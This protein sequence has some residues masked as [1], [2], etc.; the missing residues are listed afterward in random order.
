MAGGPGSR[1]VGCVF[2][3]SLLQ[4]PKSSAAVYRFGTFGSQGGLRLGSKLGRLQPQVTATGTCSARRKRT[5]R[6]YAADLGMPLAV[7]A[8]STVSWPG[9]EAF[10]TVKLLTMQFIGDRSCALG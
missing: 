2:Y 4:L 6:T 5:S 3:T 1:V 8:R 7:H 9:L 10:A